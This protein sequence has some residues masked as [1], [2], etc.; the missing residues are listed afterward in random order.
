M[1]IR[2]SFLHIRVASQTKK[3]I[4]YGVTRMCTYGA[5]RA[6]NLVERSNGT[7]FGLLWFSLVFSN[8]PCGKHTYASR[9]GKNQIKQEKTK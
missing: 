2:E 3:Y 9:L 7:L 8:P 5:V 6:A 4:A 1:I